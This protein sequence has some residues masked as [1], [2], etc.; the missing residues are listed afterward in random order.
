M[1][2]I[3]NNKKHNFNNHK[4]YNT[5]SEKHN[6]YI[7]NVGDIFLLPLPT[8]RKLHFYVL[9]A[10]SYGRNQGLFVNFSSIDSKN[11]HDKR[12]YDKSCT[13][14]KSDNIKDKNNNLIIKKESFINFNCPEELND[15]KLLNMIS[16]NK[17]S[18]YIGRVSKHVLNKIVYNAVNSC[19]LSNNI[20]KKY[21]NPKNKFVKN[22]INI[23]EGQQ[24][25]IR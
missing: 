21:L 15:I 11:K 13:F 24:N 7:F 12:K 10:Y 2:Q 17:S 9:I 6:N 23:V 25:K 19:V 3:I 16:N 4:N 8:V 14:N 1:I 5:N 22:I 18:R 20:K